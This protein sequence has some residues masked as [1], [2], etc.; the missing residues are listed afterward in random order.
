MWSTREDFVAVIVGQAPM[1]TPLFRRNFW[2]KAGYATDN[3]S[4]P[5]KGYRDFGRNNGQKL[6]DGAGVVDTIGESSYNPR[7]ARDPHSI[8]QIEM[9]ESQEMTVLNDL[10]DLRKSP[11]MVDSATEREHIGWV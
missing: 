9:A 11:R 5:R 1:L 3:S 10:S 7:K 2:V 6:N 8:T 4:T